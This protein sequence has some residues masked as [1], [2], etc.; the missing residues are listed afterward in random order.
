MINMAV[1]GLCKYWSTGAIWILADNF[2]FISYVIKV[3]FF[4]FESYFSPKSFSYRSLYC[5]TDK[6]SNSVRAEEQ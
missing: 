2:Y 1:R 3:Y 5:D 6:N 4:K